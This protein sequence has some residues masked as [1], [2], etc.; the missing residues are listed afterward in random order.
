[1][2]FAK[3]LPRD[4]QFFTLFAE[5]AENG[6]AGARVLSTVVRNGATPERVAELQRLE[7]AGDDVTHRIFQA[8]NSTFVTP[9]DRDDIHA[10]ASE[11]DDFIDHLNDAGQRLGLYNLGAVTEITLQLSDILVAQAERLA[12]I[13]P[14]LDAMNKHREALR[15]DILELHRL[16][17]DAD[18]LQ[19]ESLAHQYDGVT[20]VQ[21]LITVMRWSE[22]HTALILA[23]DQAESV[24]NTLEGM[25]LKYA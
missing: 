16:E 8:L 24:A 25:L 17:N 10:L 9:I 1:M 3:F 15:S 7:Q 23:T 20:E 6:A 4:E 11:L 14:L 2:V 12:H 19:S 5:A 22:I 18:R 21:Q 13:M